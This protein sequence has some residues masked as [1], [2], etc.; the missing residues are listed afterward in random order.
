MVL[1]LLPSCK[2]NPQLQIMELYS[3]SG[4]AAK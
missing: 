4:D 1:H 2:N 3:V